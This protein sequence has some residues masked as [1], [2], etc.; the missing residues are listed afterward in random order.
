MTEAPTATLPR[1]AAVPP[2]PLD[3]RATALR[4]DAAR[5]RVYGPVDLEVNRGWLVAV[6]GPQGS[7]RTSL[8]LTLAGRMRPGAGSLEVLGHRLPKGTGDVHRHTALALFK[9]VDA[10]DE[11]LRIDELIRE[12]AGLNVPLW[13]RPL[14]VGDARM[15]TY[16]EAAFGEPGLPDPR[17]KVWDL[18]P[19]Q[20][21]QLRLLLALI[22][23]PRLLVVD[24]VDQ[25]R[26]PSEQREL[27][28]SLQRICGLGIT[29][30][31]ASTSTAA[32]PGDIH[33]IDLAGGRP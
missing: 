20:V 9:A 29:V 21:A 7:G 16:G 12:Q 1:K 27:W 28:H 4:L 33:V 2:P 3:I 11:G 8:L 31:A 30:V 6:V 5:G 22:G 14:A 10:L 17:L 32:I 19:L 18:A 13:R 15:T 26:D 25:V 23:G 24:D